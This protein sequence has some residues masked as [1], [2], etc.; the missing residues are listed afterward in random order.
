MKQLNILAATLILAAC[1]QA[2]TITA[3]SEFAPGDDCGSPSCPVIGDRLAFDIQKLMVSVTPTTATADLYFN[4]G[5]GNSSLTPFT[6]GSIQ[7]NPSDLLF[8]LGGTAVFAVPLQDHNG[9]PNGGPSGGLLQAGHLYSIG[10]NGVV[11]A[12]Q[13][14]NTSSYEYRPT[15]DV[16]AYNDGQGSV[17]DLATGMVNVQGGGDGVT[18]AKFHV[19]ITFTPTAQF[20][21]D[22]NSA[23]FGVLFTNATC[24]NDVLI[25]S[26]VPEPLTFIFV[27]TGLI[28]L[29]LI[30]RLRLGRPE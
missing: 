15:V 24:A 23:D 28:A 11:T 14:L 3:I 8:T 6:V 21:A 16:W 5:F 1:G 7:L 20:V 26:A 29:S 2:A 12:G 22:S 30:R 19:Q 13:V 9:S 18:N 25:G 4:F 27:G 10:A 17:Q